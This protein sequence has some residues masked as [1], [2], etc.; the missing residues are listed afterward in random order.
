M[1][2]VWNLPVADIANFQK[3]VCEIRME[4]MLNLLVNISLK[5]VQETFNKYFMKSGNERSMEPS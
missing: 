3:E 4:Y 5:Y 1:K 2:E